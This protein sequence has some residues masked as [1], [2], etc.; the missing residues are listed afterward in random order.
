MP[1]K[2]Y[3]FIYTHTHTEWTYKNLTTIWRW[4]TLVHSGAS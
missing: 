1:D 3:V 4:N 2:A